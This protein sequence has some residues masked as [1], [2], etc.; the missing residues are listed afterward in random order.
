[1]K[2]KLGTVTAELKYV[3]PHHHVAVRERLQRAEAVLRL[4][5][6]VVAAVA[7]SGEPRSLSHAYGALR[8]I[9]SSW[10]P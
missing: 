8:G 6:D 10:K 2:S 5:Q 4:M 7:Q 9:L 3:S 1:M